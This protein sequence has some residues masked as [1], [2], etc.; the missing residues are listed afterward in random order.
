M[1]TIA[2]LFGVHILGVFLRPLYEKLFPKLFG[3]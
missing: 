2:I 1:G 3:K